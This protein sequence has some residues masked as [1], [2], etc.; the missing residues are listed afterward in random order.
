MEKLSVYLIFFLICL[1]CCTLGPDDKKKKEKKK[2]AEPKKKQLQATKT[3]LGDLIRREIESAQEIIE[4]HENV[5][6][7]CTNEKKI[8][9][10]LLGYVTPWNSKGY[11]IT[12]TFGKK[13][14]YISPVW[15]QVNLILNRIFDSFIN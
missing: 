4:N 2:A 13:F 9:G 7:T 12:K 10:K 6:L 5:C 14:D 15:L 8:N 3:D 1:A 11:E